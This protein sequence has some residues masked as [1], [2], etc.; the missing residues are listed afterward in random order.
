MIE[1]AAARRAPEVKVMREELVVKLDNASGCVCSYGPVVYVVWRN[2][3]RL[4]T[5]E[6]ADDVVNDLHKRYGTGKKLFYV[7]RNPQSRDTLRQNPAL[8]S[9]VMRHFE[10]TEPLMVGAGIAIEATGFGGSI[11]RSAAAAVVLLRNASLPTKTFNDARAAVRWLGDLSRTTN[12]FNC[13]HM[14]QTLESNHLAL[15]GATTTP[16]ARAAVRS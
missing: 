1:G 2:F 14:I 16:A 13:E 15:T 4:E 5:V 6:A 11:I 8:R 7:N 10:R 3:D 12:P 9:A